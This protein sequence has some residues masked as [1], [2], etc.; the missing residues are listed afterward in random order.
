[1]L[2]ESEKQ[3]A[4]RGAAIKHDKLLL[5]RL[6]L[7]RNVDLH[8]PEMDS[9]LSLCMYRTLEEGEELLSKDEENEHLFVLMS[10]RL[11]ITLTEH[12]D[13][14]LTIVEPGECVG[15]MSLIERRA[16]SAGVKASETATVLEIDQETL[17]RM[18]SASH[19]I[20]R[21]LLYIMSER[22]RYSN[23]VRV[24]VDTVCW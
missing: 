7:F 14:L 1:M 8:S 3:K 4:M 16:P 9:F 2:V 19:E 24:I 17:W 12:E 20:S 23:L 15:E 21:N 11:V 13:S 22:L 6:Q 5:S 18:V 10:G